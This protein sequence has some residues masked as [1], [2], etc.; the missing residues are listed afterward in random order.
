MRLNKIV[1][2][3]RDIFDINHPAQITSTAEAPVQCVNT[4]MSSNAAR[5]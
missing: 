5:D 4:G 1:K 3:H 2:G